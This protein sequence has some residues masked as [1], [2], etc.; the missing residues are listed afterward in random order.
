MASDCYS[1]YWYVFVIVLDQCAN[2]IVF[3]CRIVCAYYI[4]FDSKMND[5]IQVT[6]QQFKELGHCDNFIKMCHIHKIHTTS[7][8]YKQKL[9]ALVHNCKASH[10]HCWLNTLISKVY[11]FNTTAFWSS[12]WVYF[13]S[14]LIF[15]L[16][17]PLHSN[18][19]KN[20]V[21]YHLDEYVNFGP[22]SFYSP[23]K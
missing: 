2:H 1:G 18:I 16:S 11:A 21:T 3:I 4:N 12:L 17:L 7:W 23:R 22:Y 19:K 13:W 20:N 15:F 14:T 6:I 9:E 8:N 10:N 5:V